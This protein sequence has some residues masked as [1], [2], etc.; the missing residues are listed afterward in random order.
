MAD[1]F[2][3]RA[4]PGKPSG[5]ERLSRITAKLSISAPSNPCIFVINAVKASH[6]SRPKALLEAMQ[7]FEGAAPND[8]HP[9]CLLVSSGRGIE[10]RRV[11][12]PYEIPIC[13]LLSKLLSSEGP[14]QGLNCC[15]VSGNSAQQKSP[16]TFATEDGLLLNH[17]KSLLSCGIKPPQQQ[18]EHN[19]AQGERQ[20]Q[21]QRPLQP[22]PPQQ[23]VSSESLA[24]PK[25]FL[26]PLPRPP[27]LRLLVVQ[28]RDG[29]TDIVEINSWEKVSYLESWAERR[30]AGFLRKTR[31]S[32]LS[33][34]ICPILPGSN[35]K[36][37]VLIFLGAPLCSTKTLRESGVQ[38]HD[39]VYIH[40]AS[41]APPL[42]PS[43]PR[44]GKASAGTAAES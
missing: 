28:A 4:R 2:A 8:V 32:I 14:L 13:E 38:Q 15:K 11:E 20:H 21:T 24:P 17:Q 27:P 10:E 43:P 5:D 39:T 30:F 25:L 44:P 1:L 40:F 26:T 42:P 6:H 41:D 19:E 22:V 34:G 9:L 23:L 16:Y 35:G 7:L 33:D 12:C 29:K 3:V 36:G 37:F 31:S 18:Q